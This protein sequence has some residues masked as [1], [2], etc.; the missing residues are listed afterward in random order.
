MFGEKL[1][2]KLVGDSIITV[3]DEVKSVVDSTNF[4]AIADKVLNK[5]EG[6]F[7]DDGMADDMVEAITA[8]IRSRLDVED[9]DP[10]N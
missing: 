6:M 9:S 10:E 3:L 1:A 5:L 8:R 4:K 7:K 2:D